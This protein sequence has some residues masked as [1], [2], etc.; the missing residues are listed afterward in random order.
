MPHFRD[1][2]AFCSNFYQAPITGKDGRVWPTAEHYFQAL[3]TDVVAEQEAIRKANSAAMAK[4]L[5]KTVTLRKDWNAK[6]VALMTYVVRAKFAQNP[7]L[8]AKLVAT[9]GE[10]VELNEWGDKYWG[11][12]SKTNDGENHLGKILM[13]VRAELSQQG[14]QE[15]PLK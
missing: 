1:N 3:K 6:R 13:L 10:L 12:C 11:V 5:G 14:Q 8:A 7:K 4:K 15:L 2:L 9:K